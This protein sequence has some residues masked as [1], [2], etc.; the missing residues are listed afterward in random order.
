MEALSMV[1]GVGSSIFLIW[2]AISIDRPKILGLSVIVN[3]FATLQYL[4][5]EQTTGAIICTLGTIR[6]LTFLVGTRVKALNHWSVLI[7]FV[8]LTIFVSLFFMEW[9]TF[10]VLQILPIIGSVL[11]SVGMFMQ[12]VKLLKILTISASGMWV[13]YEFGA[14]SF[15]QLPGELFNMLG[16]AW[17]LYVIIAAEHAGR[18]PVE[19]TQQIIETITTSIP[20]ITQS[21]KKVHPL[22]QGNTVIPPEPA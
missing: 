5:L 8:T 2:A 16:Q 4:A 21:I 17:A 22:T 18:K 11:G 13:V 14:Q 9:S 7:I 20:V 1:L 6:C 19:P 15:G 10:T 12:N 3:L